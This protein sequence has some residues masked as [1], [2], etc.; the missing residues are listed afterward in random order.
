MESLKLKYITIPAILT[1]LIFSS[2]G[3]S[4]CGYYIKKTEKFKKPVNTLYKTKKEVLTGLAKNYEN[5]KGMSGRFVIT[6]YGSYFPFEEAG[7]Y[8]YVKDKYIKFTILDMYGDQL[9]Y[10]KIIKGKDKVF[11]LVRGKKY[12]GKRLLHEKLFRAFRIFLN[13]NSLYKIKN[14]DVFYNTGSGFFFE[15][16]KKGSGRHGHNNAYYIYV[17]RKYLIKKITVVKHKKMLETIYFKDYIPKGGV[18]IPLKIVVDDYLYN[19]KIKVAV[20]KGSKVFYMNDF[21]GEQY[22]K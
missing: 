10:A 2:L 6:A 12:Q 22:E 14:S 18:R 17:D 1:I 3:F 19:V 16:H 21:N 15:Y 7:L 11:F 13:L 8:K 4:G 5:F 20:S 9:F